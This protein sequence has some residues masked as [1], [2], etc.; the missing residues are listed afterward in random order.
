MSRRKDSANNIQSRRTKTPTALIIH[1]AARSIVAFRLS[2]KNRPQRYRSYGSAPFSGEGNGVKSKFFDTR[3]SKELA[4]ASP[5][6]GGQGARSYEKCSHPPSLRP[7]GA[8]RL[9]S[10]IV[11]R[12]AFSRYDFLNLDG[13]KPSR[14]T[15]SLQSPKSPLI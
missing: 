8:E 2:S 14:I 4:T 9:T 11:A 7:P 5:S 13:F 1:S 10:D 12:S 3:T 6:S 15:Y